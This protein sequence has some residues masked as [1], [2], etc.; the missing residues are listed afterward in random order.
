[1]SITE[2]FIELLNVLKEN[3]RIPNISEIFFP[4]KGGSDPNQRFNNFGA[5]RLDDNSIGINYLGLSEDVKRRAQNFNTKTL[6]GGNPYSL[7]KRVKS[8]DL[9]HR[10]LAFGVINAISQYFFKICQYSLDFT[11][12]SLGLLNLKPADSVGMV[13]FFP[14]LIK[15]IKKRGIS[16]VVLEKKEHLL[17]KHENWEVT[18]DPQRLEECNK[19]LSTSSTVLNNSLDQIL[20]HCKNAEMISIIGPTAGFIPDPLFKRGVNVLGGTYVSN[21]P[22][23]TDLVSQNEKWGKST[24]KYCIQADKYPGFRTLLKRCSNSEEI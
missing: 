1:V 2:D 22:L 18:S 23:F 5:V 9:F 17:Q 20:N 15:R 14:P 24:K 3:I 21:P 8:D 10:T 7:A 13:G 6:E 11:T 4:T 19:V 12:N 16:L